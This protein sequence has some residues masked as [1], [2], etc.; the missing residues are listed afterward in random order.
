MPALLQLYE[1]DDE[2]ISDEGKQL[3]STSNFN[4]GD[5]NGTNCI[6]GKENSVNDKNYSKLKFIVI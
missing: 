4:G 3:D 1:S 6:K 5:P 2:R